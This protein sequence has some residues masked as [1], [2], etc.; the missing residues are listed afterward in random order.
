MPTALNSVDAWKDSRAALVDALRVVFELL[1]TEPYSSSGS[2]RYQRLQACANRI[3][4]KLR[5]IALVGLRQ[6]D[7]TIASGQQI[8]Q[9]NGLAKQAKQ[10][11]AQLQR[12]TATINGIASAIDDAVSVV[13]RI[14]GLPFV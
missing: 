5:L 1:E 3:L 14:V 8:A 10:Q 11:A 6:I 13:D 2:S 12:A 9:L 4:D 7:D